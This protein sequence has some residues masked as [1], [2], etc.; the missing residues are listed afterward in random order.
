MTSAIR[1]AAADFLARG[2]TPIPLAYRSKKPIDKDWPSLDPTEEDLDRLFPVDRPRNLG[3]R[4]G[5]TS[6]LVDVD[7]DC[8]E[9]RA[10]AAVLLPPTGW[11]HGRPSAP[12]SHYWYVP[13]TLPRRSRT[14][15]KGLDGQ[16]LVELR[17]TGFQTVVPPSLHPSG[18]P[19]SWQQFQE[20]G[21]LPLDTL[22]DAVH[23]VA[24]AALLARHW[25]APGSR[26][27]AF[28]ALGGGLLR[29]G[30]TTAQAERFIEAVATATRDEETDKRVATV[31]GTAGKQQEGQETIGWPRLADLLRPN[32]DDVIVHVRRWLCMDREPAA[33][34]RRSAPEPYLPFPVETLPEPMRSFVTQWSAAHGGDAALVALPAL[35]AVASAIGATRV[36]RLKHDW[37][38]PC[39][40]WTC[41]VS[42]SGTL[43]SP[44]FHAAIDPL[45]RR[46]RRLYLRWKE[47]KAVYEDK[48]AE[49]KEWR[50]QAK[51]EGGGGQPPALPTRPRLVT[52]D[53]TIEQ[54]AQILDEN[55]RGVLLGCDE[56]AGWF[57][58]FGRYKPKAG[59]TDLP[60]W[61]V[62]HQ[63]R[64]LLVDRKTGEK[65]SLSIPRAAVSVTG[66]IQP[67]TL[68]RQLTAEFLDHGLAARLLIARPPRVLKRW[69]EIEVHPDVAAAYD[70]LFDRLLILDFSTDGNGEAVP[71]IVALTPE[72]KALWREYYNAWAKQQHESADELA[73]CYS[74][75]EGYA[76]RLALV[77]HLV[78]GSDGPLTTLSM[79]AGITLARWFAHEARRLYR[80][81]AESPQERELRRLV[82]YIRSHGGRVSARQLQRFNNRRYATAAAAETALEELVAAGVARW[83][84]VATT[85]AG[86]RPIKAVELCV[87][88]D[89]GDNGDDGA[90]L[91]E[92]DER[93]N[94]PPS[95]PEAPPAS[96]PSSNVTIVTRH[97]EGRGAEPFRLVHD[98]AQLPEL[99]QTLDGAARVALDCET[100]GLDPRRDR[101]R[102]LF[103]A[104]ERGIFVLDCFAVDPRPLWP[105]LA[106]TT[107]I[108]HHLAF[109][110]A[111]L[112][113]LDFEP[114]AVQDTMLLSQLQ[115]AG[116]VQS[117]KLR[118]CVHRELGRDL[119]KH[120]QSSDWSGPLSAEQLAY[121][122]AD[123]EVL[124]PLCDAL[125][126]KVKAHALA[127]AADIEQR[128]LPA[129]VWLA[130]AG[131]PFDRDA[132]AALAALAEA[133]ARELAEEA[134]AI[135]RERTPL[136]VQNWD[137][138][139]QVKE[140][141]AALGITLASTDNE[142]LAAVP[143]P[144]AAVLRRY[145]EARKR[146]TAF[147]HDWLKH[148]SLPSL[149]LRGRGVGGE[150]VCRI[151]ASW[152]QLGAAS[153]RM[154]C[155]SPNLQQLPRG[156]YRASI[157]A[158]PGRVLVKADY[159]Q[160]ELRIAA[161]IS[162]DKA[163][164][165]AYR[166][167]QDLHLLT[168]QRLLGRKDVTKADRQI[169]KSAN[170]G[171]LY[172][173]GARGYQA[174][175]RA[176][177]GVELTEEAAAGYRDAF[178]RGY[179]GLAA[180]HR[181][182][183][184]VQAME[185]RTRAGRRRK[186]DGQARDT[187]RLNSPVQGTGADGLK[188]ALALL[189]ERRHAVPGAVPILAVHD[190]IVV[191]CALEQADAV[192][193]WL[194][195]A[196]LDGM[197]PLID[198]V[199][200]EVEVRVGRT[201]MGG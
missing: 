60:H 185:T 101:L 51:E 122:R 11:I 171:L 69:T 192:S 189:W 84:A 76:A 180:W 66:T 91:E 170:F 58:S 134:D 82:E 22:L 83:I 115:D 130:G 123:A 160:I 135:L 63:A 127:K 151:Y 181:R 120:L 191:E 99:F 114:G 47:Q 182:V 94:G 105:T 50:R 38:E 128:C 147:G 5:G 131:V 168:A 34:A 126:A 40:L 67:G 48:L 188:L 75:L 150:G 52:S 157:A 172:G 193:A 183:K 59:G 72:A 78:T 41:T 53:I 23:Q 88:H 39:V 36:L 125:S 103:L 195:Q 186:L 19:L 54:L 65:P 153:G 159:S 61:L 18:E 104:T 190:E 26:Q 200:V 97:A 118:D 137:S 25:P 55:P 17:S 199:P 68:A 136:A 43:K 124:L 13:D 143:H 73:A 30:Y 6:G 152:H 49:Y 119:D 139:N 95:D 140:A 44:A 56:L 121:T 156:R 163:M 2:Q 164:Q 24:A 32:G 129:L 92:D 201:W 62:M 21:A 85:R 133:E 70:A 100:T 177:Y 57:G 90:E 87:T 20:P 29:G 145:R 109:D 96:P 37:L 12:A 46:E 107:L 142:H 98:P 15:F 175:A 1:Q 108:G 132:W 166:D 111:F 9:A 178:F 42:E 184:K 162:G 110:L 71:K 194:Q 165:E 173:M 16:M 138:P 146:A 196:M 45:L 117:H 64:P 187:L 167:G 141:F 28:L 198:P 174:Y 197:A 3:L 149:P 113:G 112:A 158:P 27:D 81:L 116:L 93:P 161:A 169:A 80:L 4:L 33:P 31:A 154:S 10:A 102:L 155:S 79:Q 106:K 86:G 89:N 148:A 77:H 35:A 144:L 14:A 176:N 74:K 7:L 8:P 179:P